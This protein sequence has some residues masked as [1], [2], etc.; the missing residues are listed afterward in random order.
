MKIQV[1]QSFIR[2][3]FVAV[4]FVSRGTFKIFNFGYVKNREL[5]RFSSFYLVASEYV[6]SR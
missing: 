4:F 3:I 6:N 1:V 5:S 2:Y